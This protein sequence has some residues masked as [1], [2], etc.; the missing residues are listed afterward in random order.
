MNCKTYNDYLIDYDGRTWQENRAIVNA[1]IMAIKY[2]MDTSPLVYTLPLGL[3]DNA[4]Q[5]CESVLTGEH[6]R[7][8]D[9]LIRHSNGKAMNTAAIGAL[10]G[11]TGKRTAQRAVKELVDNG[12]FLKI[13][14]GEYRLNDD[15][16]KKVS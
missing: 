6:V 16:L 8:T 11:I 14:R 4:I 3:S 13:K 5:V 10:A 15:I 1:Q 2:K 9:K 12:V 7:P